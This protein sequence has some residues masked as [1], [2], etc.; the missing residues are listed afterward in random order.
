MRTFGGLLIFLAIAAFL[1]AFFGMDTSVATAGNKR[2]H[3]IGLMNTQQNVN[4]LA[5]GLFIGGVILFAV[6]SMRRVAPKAVEPQHDKLENRTCP[7]CGEQIKK[8]AKLC[9]HCK[10]PVEPIYVDNPEANRQIVLVGTLAVKGFS[11]H[12]I[13]QE[14]QRRQVACLAPNESWSAAL[15]QRLINNFSLASDR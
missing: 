4:I 14:L 11:P 13:A 12:Q 9:K 15:V 10:S 3:N 1:F 8:I 2:V 6:G 7:H 5:V